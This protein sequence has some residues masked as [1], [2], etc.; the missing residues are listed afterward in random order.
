MAASLLRSSYRSTSTVA[1]VRPVCRTSA[2]AYAIPRGTDR[3]SWICSERG[4]RSGAAHRATESIP[5]ARAPPYTAPQLLSRWS[6][7]ANAQPASSG[8]GPPR[9]PLTE[10]RTSRFTAACRDP[11]SL[12]TTPHPWPLPAVAFP[13]DRTLPV[14]PVLPTRAFRGAVRTGSGRS[15]ISN[16]LRGAMSRRHRQPGQP[17]RTRTSARTGQKGDGPS[18]RL[19]LHRE[20]RP[21]QPHRGGP[22][23][24]RV[25][26]A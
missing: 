13:G 17:A 4:E 9:N 24:R 26:P 6:P 1:T 25:G 18:L 15:P 11:S 19:L 21:E 16:R 8:E 2:V 14:S 5:A 22:Y 20:L 12:P 23:W 7:N 10:A 3:T